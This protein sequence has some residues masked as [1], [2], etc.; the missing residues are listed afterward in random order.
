[1]E[2]RQ[3]GRARSPPL[4]SLPQTCCIK[5]T[6]A[7]LRT[8]VPWTALL[9]T[10]PQT[11]CRRRRSRFAD[12]EPDRLNISDALPSPSWGSLESCSK[13]P[14][15][16]GEG[17]PDADVWNPEATEHPLTMLREGQGFLKVPV[18]EERCRRAVWQ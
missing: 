7:C 16:L 13:V 9:G 14:G 6:G 5:G 10:Y 3:R 15:A 4:V 11:C 8:G 2:W 1:M 18:A 12:P 17:S